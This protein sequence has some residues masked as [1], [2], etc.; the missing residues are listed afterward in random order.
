M[1]ENKESY[2]PLI[3]AC[4]RRS[5][6]QLR[7]HQEIKPNISMALLGHNPNDTTSCCLSHLV[8]C[9]LG[10]TTVPRQTEG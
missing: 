2:E 4:S 3:D 9:C 5:K 6:Q 10:Q 7:W 8:S 1:R